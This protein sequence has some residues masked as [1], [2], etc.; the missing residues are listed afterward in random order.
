MLLLVAFAG[1]LLFGTGF[2]VFGARRYRR[3]RTWPRVDGTVTHVSMRTGGGDLEGTLTPT[4]QY[5]TLDGRQ[6][7]VR[8]SAHDN[9]HVYRVGRGLPVRYDPSDPERMVVDVAGQNGLGQALLG[10]AMALLSGAVLL[11]VVLLR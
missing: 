2:A 5:T 10:G 7:E 8:S 6:L 11:A 9:V 3:S 4:M 1:L